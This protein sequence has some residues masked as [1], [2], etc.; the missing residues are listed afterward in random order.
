MKISFEPKKLDLKVNWKISRNEALFKENV[1][2]KLTHG[3]QFGL[4]EVAPNIRYNET[5]DLVLKQLKEFPTVDEPE[6]LLEEVSHS[7]V[8]HSLKN[9]LVCAAIDL[10]CKLKGIGVEEFLNLTSLR[11]AATSIS[12]PIM[13]QSL[14]ESYVSD[15]NRFKFIKIKVNE[16]NCVDF[17]KQVAKFSSSPIRIDANEAFTSLDSFQ[18]FVDQVSSLNI[19]FIEQPFKASDVEL[20]R[21][22]KGQTP[23]EIMADESIEDHAD[24][25]T[26]SELFDSVNVKLMKAGGYLQAKRLT[27]GAKSKGLKVMLGCMIESSVGIRNALRLGSLAD[28][29]DLDGSLLIKNDP[30]NK[31][32]E[33]NGLVSLIED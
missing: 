29:F 32:H 6:A 20:Y 33:S 16:L 30:Y 21:K 5:L 10:I 2:I 31:I 23:F 25:Q 15:I 19:Q 4:G 3:G 18:K 26:L 13:D 11:V 8:C 27:E 7:K 28:Y 1:F 17:T 9:G 14:V 22:I 24:F 12:V